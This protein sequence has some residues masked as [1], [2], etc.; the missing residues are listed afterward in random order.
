MSGALAATDRGEAARVALRSG[1]EGPN[2]LTYDGTSEASD[3][4]PN[5]R[6]V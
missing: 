4:D 3:L 2:R 1:A 6:G 5:D